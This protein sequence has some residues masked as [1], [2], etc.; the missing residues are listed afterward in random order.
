MLY[1]LVNVCW[2]NSLDGACFTMP[3]QNL[4]KI[5]IK[6]CFALDITLDSEIGRTVYLVICFMLNFM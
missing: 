2:V 6:R 1:I 3:P 4:L 5:P